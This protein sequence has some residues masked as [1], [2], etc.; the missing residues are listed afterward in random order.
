MRNQKCRTNVHCI[1]V[2]VVDALSG[3]LPMYPVPKITTQVNTKSVK[4]MAGGGAANTASA[5]GQMGVS[6]AV[7]SKVG[8]DMNGNF[9]RAE[10]KRNR[11]E[12]SH[13]R[14]SAS[15]S[16]PFTFV[17][18]HP[19]GDRSFVHTP[20]SNLTFS[21]KDLDLEALYACKVLLYQDMWV[22]PKLDGPAAGRIL[23]GAQKRGVI[24]LLDECYGLGPDRDVFESALRFCDV[25]LPSYDDMRVIYPGLKPAAV[26][27]RLRQQG[28]GRVILKLGRQ[29]CLVTGENGTVR[30]PSVATKI[31][32]TTGAGD[33]F[34][35]GYIAGIVNGLGDVDAAK[36]GGLT[37]AACIRHVGG[38]VG[39]PGYKTVAKLL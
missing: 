37:A 23:A 31:V 24:T 29:G 1:G 27:A 25:V 30:L 21:I 22:L 18:V 14:E 13:I 8:A 4:F 26:A 20:G 5:L 3:P 11:V 35:A 28:A 6:V 33:C 39:I 2:L 9:L 32:D 12:V 38:A 7:F 10:L 16:T 15:E 36:L 19:G 34:N 17:G